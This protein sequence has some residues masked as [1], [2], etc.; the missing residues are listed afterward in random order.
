M[1][2]FGRL[3]LLLLFLDKIKIGRLI[4]SSANKSLIHL[5]QTNIK[6]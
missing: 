3:L 1:L 5:V 6:K 2:I 4:G